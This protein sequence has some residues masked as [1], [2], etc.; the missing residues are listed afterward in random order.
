V[1]GRFPPAIVLYRI[2]PRGRNNAVSTFVFLLNMHLNYSLACAVAQATRHSL[3]NHAFINVNNRIIIAVCVFEAIT[4]WWCKNFKQGT[5]LEQNASVRPFCLH[6]TVFK[7]P[8]S[9]HTGNRTPCISYP[10]SRRL[11]LGHMQWI[12][13]GAWKNKTLA[14]YGDSNSTRLL[15]LN[16]APTVGQMQR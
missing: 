1:L 9:P 5:L 12:D 16:Q 15:T 10:E 13:E 11:S 2:T 4:Q 6:R 14:A 8:S 3:K 7:T